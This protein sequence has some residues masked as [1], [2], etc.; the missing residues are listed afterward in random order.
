MEEYHKQFPWFKRSTSLACQTD[1]KIS[2]NKLMGI[3]KI[4]LYEDCKSFF[5]FFSF[6]Y[7]IFFEWIF[8]YNLLWKIHIFANTISHVFLLVIIEWMWRF[9]I[10]CFIL[11]FYHNF[12]SYKNMLTILSFNILNHKQQFFFHI[13]NLHYNLFTFH[14]MRWWPTSCFFFSF[15]QF[16]TME[17]KPLWQLLSLWHK[18][19]CT[20]VLTMRHLLLKRH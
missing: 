10:M 16:S 15:I 4:T 8:F 17:F 3:N 2:Q 1:N 12:K 14:K 5:S 9:Q 18:F 19:G 6:S 13:Y 20:S 7:Y 11:K